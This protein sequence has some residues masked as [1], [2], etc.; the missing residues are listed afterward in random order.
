MS[1]AGSKVGGTY[2]A[3]PAP[4][5]HCSTLII[6]ILS[7]SVF[8]I[9]KYGVTT[10]TANVLNSLVYIMSAAISPFLG[11]IV[12]KTGFNLFWSE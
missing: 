1:L 2:W 4:F 5:L 11:V 8:L 7:H 3:C 12:D 9:D 10:Q 6:I